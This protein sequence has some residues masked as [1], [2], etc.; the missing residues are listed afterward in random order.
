MKAPEGW[1]SSSFPWVESDTRRNPI[2][3]TRIPEGD[4][5]L[6]EHGVKFICKIMLRGGGDIKLCFFYESYDYKLDEVT[7]PDRFYI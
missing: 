3:S 6:T 7:I 2:S 1:N 5:N 4:V